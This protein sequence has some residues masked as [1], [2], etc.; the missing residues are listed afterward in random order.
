[1]LAFFFAFQATLIGYFSNFS[2]TFGVVTFKWNIY[3]IPIGKICVTLV[4]AMMFLFTIWSLK[5][6]RMTIDYIAHIIESGA[7]LEAKI[8][9]LDFGVFSVISANRERRNQHSMLSS[10]TAVI[11]WVI[12]FLW[13]VTGALVWV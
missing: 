1:M 4:C 5:M 13:L 3:Q 6:V 10:L 11:C 9:N 2:N 7:A 12:S 8:G